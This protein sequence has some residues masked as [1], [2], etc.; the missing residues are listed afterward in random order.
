MTRPGLWLALA[1]F[2]L[3]RLIVL[4]AAYTAPQDRTRP[5]APD[6]WSDVPMVRWD[7]GHYL[8]IMEVGYPPQ[9]ND[10]TAFFPLYP[11]LAR[12]LAYL[13]P[14]DVALVV[15]SHLA[16]TG[17]M[18]L[19]YLWC[20][21][22]AGEAVGF[23]AV[24]LLSTFPTAMFLS[25][26][27]SEGLFLL[28]VALALWFIQGRLW[29]PAALTCALAT[30]TRPTGLALAAVF[31][32]S[33]CA[34]D[35][36]RPL[37]RRLIRLAGLGVLSVSGLIAFRVYLWHHYGRIDAWEAAQVTWSRPA[38][39]DPLRKLVLLHP[40][41][42]PALQPIRCV[43]RGEFPRLPDPW[44]WNMTINVAVL[45]VAGV[46][47]ARPGPFP[48]LSFLLPIFVFLMAYLPDP[49]L[50]T[51]LVGIARYQL[52][53]LPCLALLAAPGWLGRRPVALAVLLLGGLLLQVQ[54]MRLFCNWIL[55][56]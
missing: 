18:V 3:T 49:F 14:P 36:G 2:A 17:A 51:R 44:T 39:R 28:W 24:L 31:C 15:L 40:I 32:L 10:T 1:F 9:I 5:Q 52:A 38:V 46:G 55:V 23:R 6:W 34:A 56:S 54:Y 22:A 33:A 26:G 37:P 13:F 4:V 50:G 42:K 35:R 45:A 29:W 27:Y 8:A 11:L 48:R 41:V 19:F 53:A 47:L 21:R 20:R 16:A 30:A 43:L 25:T 12:P 7:A